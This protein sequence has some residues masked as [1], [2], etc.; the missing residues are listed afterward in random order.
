MDDGAQP[1][2]AARRSVAPAVGVHKC[3]IHLLLPEEWMPMQLMQMH[4]RN[5]IAEL[6]M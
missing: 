5:C 3:T 2:F 4:S 6:C 1:R